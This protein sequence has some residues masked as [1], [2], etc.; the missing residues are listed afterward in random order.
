MR[1]S[2]N[3]AAP[4]TVVSYTVTFSSAV[5]ANS[6]FTAN[7]AVTATGTANATIVDINGVGT[8]YTVTLSL[9]SGQGT[10]RL[11]LIDDDSIVTSSGV[12]LGGAGAG[13]GTFTTG[14][15][16]TVGTAVDLIFRNGYE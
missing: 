8:T 16:Y 7:F 5:V 4:S 6:V 14:E 2:A 1:A 12:P 11:D 9:T 10:V 13:N 3:P 15:V